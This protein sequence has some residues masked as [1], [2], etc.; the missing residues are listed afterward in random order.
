[1]T[2]KE[3]AAD[4][5]LRRLYKRTL[6]WYNKTLKEQGGGCE[7]CGRPPKNLRLNI[8]HDHSCCKKPPVCGKCVRGLLCMICNHK[9]IGMIEK[10]KI[11][12]MAIVGYL[13]KYNGTT[14]K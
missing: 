3:R 5:R 13:N 7:I 14:K 12:P 1:L 11:P 9:V 8:D 10:F 6:S 2:V 4:L